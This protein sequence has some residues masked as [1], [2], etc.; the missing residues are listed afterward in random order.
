M[1]LPDYQ[2]VTDQ[3]VRNSFTSVW[4]SDDFSSEK[5]LT[6]T[7]IMDA[8]HDN[9]I[10]G[11]YILGENP[12]MSDPDVE[13][14]RDALAKLEHLIVQDIFI[15][16]T[17]NYAD[18]IL[19]AAAF[20]EK[21]G[22]VTNTNRQ[23]QMARPAILPPGEAKA[24]WWIEVELA[25]RVGLDWKY[26]DP[27]Q[28]FSEMAINMRSLDNITWDRLEA[29]GAVTYPSLSENDPG[30]PIVFGEGF[31][32]PEGRAKFTPASVIAPD[33]TPDVEYPMI[34]T[35]GRQLEHWHT[36]S[37]TRRSKVLDAV[38]PEAN[39]SL[40]PKTLRK[41]GVMP[42][43]F[44]KLTTRRG[45]IA[46]MARSD[47]AVSE[48]MVFLPFA[49]VEAAANILTNSAIDPYGKIPEFKFSAVRVE[50]VSTVIAA[51]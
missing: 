35:T 39:C 43:E 18:V 9:K 36:G 12:A 42:G 40:H 30:Q 14:A 1:F 45:N 2:T 24:D 20:A 8:I 49:Y 32:R 13:H 21:S 7:E 6:V 44:V 23:V 51:E 27:S 19:P 34:L 11:M 22:T 50:A 4:N 3:G 29:D 25:K 41:L 33:E 26:T 16:E 10:K 37:M 38:E 48:D 28:V 47:R 31:P 17:A 5:G 46:L 15:T